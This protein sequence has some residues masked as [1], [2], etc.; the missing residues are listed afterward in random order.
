MKAFANYLH[1]KYRLK[2]KYLPFYIKWVT[3]CYHFLN[4]PLHEPVSQEQAQ[5]FIKHLSRSREDWQVKQAEH[6]MRL[7]NYFQICIT[8]KTQ[9]NGTQQQEAWQY[10]IEETRQM[11]RLK[12]RSFRTEKTYL[13]WIGRFAVFCGWKHITKRASV[14]T[15]RHSFATHLL[16]NGYDIRTVQELLGHSNV[17]TTM[18]YTHVA[19]KNKLGVRSP[20]DTW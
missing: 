17:Q 10:I 7:Y 19:R 13:H 3:E 2:Q 5:E 15:L 12:Q 16:E 6:A 20:L 1:T 8:N 9:I 4:C 11:L 18:V 14:H